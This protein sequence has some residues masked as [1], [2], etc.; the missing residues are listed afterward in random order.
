[1]KLTHVAVPLSAPER[2]RLLAACG[3]RRGVK[4]GHWVREAILEKLDREK[5][6]KGGAA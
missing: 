6:E 1:M 3:P 2:R 5:A 4:R